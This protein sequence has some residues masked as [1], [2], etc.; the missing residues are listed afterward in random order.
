[1]A[2][3]VLMVVAFLVPPADKSPPQRLREMR[4]MFG[5]RHAGA[6]LW[7]TMLP[8]LA[9]GVFDVLAPL[10]VAYLGGTALLIAG[11]FLASAAIEATLSPL[12]GRQADRRGALAPVRISLVSGAAVSFLAPSLGR[13]WLLVPALILGMPA[14]GTLF[15][16]AMALLSESA[17]RLKLD[18]GM[19]FG[20]AN[21]AWASGQAVAAAGSGALAQATSDLVPYSL[22]G[23]ACLATLGAVRR[24]R[25]RSASRAEGQTDELA[26]DRA[27]R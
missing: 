20:L 22:L 1:V 21:L 16:P 5:D 12:A 19:A 4:P 8:G 25:P 6:G 26:A 10:R 13:V 17:H 14:F 24:R 18:Q 27:A 7:L 11:T 15:A 9:F 2:G 3:V 23:A